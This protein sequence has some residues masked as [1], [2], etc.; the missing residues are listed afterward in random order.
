MLRQLAHRWAGTLTL[1]AVATLVVGL[2]APSDAAAPSAVGS[3]WKTIHGDT[4]NGIACPTTKL[5]VGVDGNKVTWTTN[6]T[7]GKPHWKHVAL[8]PYSQPDVI[9]SVILN[10]VT[11]ANAHFCLIGDDIGNTF[12]TT[13][14]TGGKSAWHKAEIDNTEIEGLSC[15]SSS[16]CAALDYSGNALTSTDPDSPTPSWSPV[17]LASDQGGDPPIVSCAGRSVCAAV[18]EGSEIYYTTNASAAPAKW[19][20][21]KLPSH[22]WD[23]VSCPTTSHCVAVGTLDFAPKVAVTNNLAAGKHSWKV[24]KV[25]NGS[26]GGL[27]QVD[28][29][30]KSFCFA[31]S[32]MF[33]SHAAAKASAWH[34]VTAPS[35][36]SQTGVSCPTTKWCFIATID[37]SLSWHR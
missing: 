34:R 29:A 3:H 14:P 8:E 25:H 10:A 7:S 26:G 20:H 12:A 28:C 30:T 33:T 9:G 23:G 6:P 1:A 18:E 32:D 13:A 31:I 15:T 35:S 24:A 19:K 11:C 2:A 4:T 5:C 21:V 37:G 27:A 22:G 17:F 36:G 16:F